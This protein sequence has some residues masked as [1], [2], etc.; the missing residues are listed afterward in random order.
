L[1]IRDRVRHVAFVKPF[2]Q[3]RVTSTARPL[4]CELGGDRRSAK[5]DFPRDQRSVLVES[6]CVASDAHRSIEVLSKVLFATP[7][8]LDR[9]SDRFRNQGRLAS[10]ILRKTA[11][12]EATSEV[13]LVDDHF[14]LS[15]PSAAATTVCVPSAFCVG[16]QSSARSADVRH[17][18][19]R[20][21]RC[22]SEIGDVVFPL[23]AFGC[24][25]QGGID[26]PLR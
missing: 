22:V 8:H 9:L 13:A 21:H 20:L 3:H 19:L 23:D 11:T 18:V 5:P 12:P 14:S 15:M 25:G 10:P 24:G 26:I 6:R 4:G 17:A 7:D 2:H 16:A 1:E